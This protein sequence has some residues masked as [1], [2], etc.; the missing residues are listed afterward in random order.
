MTQTNE[1]DLGPLTWVKSEIDQALSKAEQAL[2]LVTSSG[3]PITH[4]QFAQTHLHQACGALSIVGLGGLTQF[5]SALER[6]LDALARD[7]QVGSAADAISICQRGLASIGNYLEDIV[8]GEPDQALRLVELYAAIET[9]RGNS[10]PNPADLF[11]PNLGIKLPG[12]PTGAELN[13][14]AWRA[15]LRRARADFER[16]LLSWLKTPAKP[17]GATLMRDAAHQVQT[18]QASHSGAALWWAAQAFFDALLQGAIPANVLVRRLCTRYDKEL[19]QQQRGLR[20]VPEGLLRE[21]LYWLAHAQPGGPLQR[22]VRSAWQLDTLTPAAGSTVT[23]V[24]L[25]PLLKTLHQE[26]FAAKRAW[27]EFSDGRAASLPRF[28]SHVVRLSEL[29]LQLGRPAFERLTDGLSHFVAWLRKDPLSFNDAVGLEAASALLLVEI[30]LDRGVPESDFEKQVNDTV[31]RL[32]AVT[33]GEQ[34]PAADGSAT[35]DAARKL[36]EKQARAQVAREIISNLARVEQ[37]LDD[38]FRN[39][40][41][42]GPLAELVGPLHQIQ[43]ALALVGD[44]RAIRLVMNSA[45]TVARLAE[46]EDLDP[47][48]NETLARDL[49][50]LGFYVQALQHGPADLR[51]FLEPHAIEDTDIRTLEAEPDALEPEPDA[52]PRTAF[53]P[54]VGLE[55]VQPPIEVPSPLPSSPAPSET[56]EQTEEIDQELLEI[57]LEE[58]REVLDRIADHLDAIR[59]PESDPEALTVIRR[60][61]HTLKGSGRMVGLAELGEA[62]WGM[63]QTL[64][65]W[66][67]LDWTPDDS[68]VGLIEN[69]HD[70]FEAWV[71]QIGSG[72]GLSFDVETLMAEAERLR[73]LEAPGADVSIALPPADT[74]ALPA[75]P[76]LGWNGRVVAERPEDAAH[77]ASTDET[78]M[79][80]DGEFSLL[81]ESADADETPP[82]LPEADHTE[83]ESGL[84]AAET[85]QASEAEFEA[86]IPGE[87]DVRAEEED[88]TLVITS[89][90]DLP[91]DLQDEFDPEP[92]QDASEAAPGTKTG[93]VTTA[94]PDAEA[95]TPQTD[96]ATAAFQAET[97][98]FDFGDLDLELEVF[99]T[100]DA[101]TQDTASREQPV[102]ETG[103]DFAD[104]PFYELDTP[105]DLLEGEAQSGVDSL[106]YATDASPDD[107]A[108]ADLAEESALA[109][110]DTSEHAETAEPAEPDQVLA[111]GR[112]A[113]SPHAPTVASLRVGDV[114]LSS[115][116]YDLFRCEAKEHLASLAEA[117]D[118]LLRNPAR[119]P[120]ED[121]QRAAHTL[122]GISGTARIEAMHTLARA[123]EHALERLIEQRA[124]PTLPETS[125]FQQSVVTLETM[126]GE[127]ECLSMPLRVPELEEQLDAIGCALSTP[128]FDTDQEA[129]LVSPDTPQS[130]TAGERPDAPEIRSQPIIAAVSDMDPSPEPAAPVHDDLDAQ[131]LPIFITEGNDLLAQLHG[132]LR[133]WRS[134]PNRPEPAIATARLLHTLKGSAR[135]AG[136]MRLGEQLHQL[137]SRL[138]ATL[139]AGSE[140]EGLVDELESGLDIAART[141]E[142]LASPESAG[143]QGAGAE[144]DTISAEMETSEAGGAASATLRVRADTIDK[145]VNQAGEI[146]IART[147]IDGELRTL[148][149]SL[150]D[151]TEN[152]IRLR[153]QLRE[154]EIQAE[155]QMQTRIAQAE[156][157]DAEF[158]PLEMDRYTRLQELTRMMAE[159]VGDVTTVQQNLLR[160]LDGAEMALNSQARMSRELQQALMQVRMVPF[161]SLADRLY[162]IVRQSAKELGKRVNLDL[163]GGR[164]ELDRGV[165]ETITPAL[166]HLLR[167]AVAH[168]IEL[169]EQRIAAGK[170][171]IGQITLS[172]RQEG[173]EIG[174]SLADD[175]A[176]IDLELIAEHARERGLL[177]DGEETDV[178][179]LT[180]LIFLPGFTTA[181][182]VSA[183]SGRGVGMDVVKAETASVGGRIDVTSTTGEGTEFRI[184]LPLTLAAT[185]ALLIRIGATT[186][187]IPSGMIAQVLEL[188]AQ[189]LEQIVSDGGVHWQEAFYPYAYLPWL[190]GDPAAHPE[191]Q[192]F[193]WVLLLR[194][195]GQTLAVQVDS[196]RGN[197]EVVVK[198]A[199]PQIVR[200]VGITGV[201]VLGDGEIVLIVNPVAFAS[202]KA[203][204][205]ETGAPAEIAPAAEPVVAQKMVMVVD[206]SLTVRKITG[207]LLEREG[208]RVIVAKDGSDA[209][210]QLIE[211]VPDVIL[212]DIEMPRMDGFD[213]LRNL[214]ADDRT[215]NVP[216][217]MITSRL[218]DKHREYAMSLGA[219]H[220]L[221][222]PY[223]E[224][225][226]LGII[227][228]LTSA[229]P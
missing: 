57:F 96:A 151:L 52:E 59:P 26:V 62:A 135:M 24:P 91:N 210:E 126:L 172:V 89:L 184:F 179:R 110:V 64:N 208:Y 147:R 98:P 124:A 53:E 177:G 222:K 192:R 132:T 213:L 44:E 150:L 129:A 85:L 74:A 218:A 219:S 189:A 206:D 160:N 203:R 123:L 87:E 187:A 66:L 164:I 211:T 45:T 25:A 63:E 119:L 162:R 195:G 75:E 97:E 49:S 139:K 170:A 157:T 60:G 220:Y 22:E 69:A 169:P 73:L 34:L 111:E 121:A 182:N 141:I 198:N 117:C 51:S 29:G 12:Q 105:G 3:E 156:S 109:P 6:L 43:G 133:E 76:Q 138:E 79:P 227:A 197:Q 205:A 95:L 209:L 99:P 153:N 80:L 77:I 118:M 149:M 122:A 55:S 196:L 18:L 168:G 186:Y 28:E 8:R 83:P 71:A 229:S 127:V 142:R 116:L 41:K 38:F 215:C 202:Q 67:Q 56:Q 19:R 9:A 144:L 221:G 88:P 65:R 100:E 145:F 50:A 13:D 86:E 180:N 114:E 154:V 17:E 47:V 21:T 163:R 161:D 137:E 194:A 173:N 106:P 200:I 107:L 193:S 115:G 136:A 11:H 20:T 2:G 48:A 32:E 181:K 224:E 131:L 216:V 226:L 130:A 82:T 10:M 14:E 58:A 7:Q 5:A 183:V 46:G 112:D 212:S 27:D 68:L 128:E 4:L 167:N 70:R 15:G 176:G 158:D 1:L 61:F 23:D 159:S 54:L 101:E 191:P 175:G 201:T 94:E 134:D 92:D 178:R 40:N 217:I 199:G 33:R 81:P 16:G 125:L 104:I 228:G 166:E 113:L 223:D 102:A 35:I 37:A 30:A 84:A 214:R 143:E 78:I 204:R 39:P 146:G 108:A 103:D 207:R 155:M 174:I 93:E 185:Q 188:K 36:N 152:V 171:P 165:L 120:D 31:A 42:R 190:L 148:R 90:E 225:E 140:T 72:Q